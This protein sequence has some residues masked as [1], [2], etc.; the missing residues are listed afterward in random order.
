MNPLKLITLRNVLILQ[1]LLWFAVGISTTFAPDL[2]R[3]GVYGIQFNPDGLW[4][5]RFGGSMTLGLAFLS[6]MLR[7]TE[8][9][10]TRRALIFLFLYIWIARAILYIMREPIGLY[11]GYGW[12][13]IVISIIATLLWLYLA[14]AKLNSDEPAAV[15]TV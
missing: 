9:H 11:R 6:W 1:A 7:D 13:D 4:F 3:A 10:K 15:A 14:V 8:D 12:V 5:A 2:G